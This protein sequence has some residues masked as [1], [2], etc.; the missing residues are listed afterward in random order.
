MSKKKPV[1]KKL[2]K[3]KFYAVHEGSKKGHPGKL[4]WKNDHKNLY[5]FI[6][7]G[8]TPSP[9]NIILI[10]PTE[11]GGEEVLCLQAAYTCEKKRRWK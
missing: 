7:T 8:T 2:W 5:L 10:V 6:K 3:G 4:Y 1:Q 11:K 9:D